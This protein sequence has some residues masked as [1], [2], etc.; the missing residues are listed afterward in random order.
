MFATTAVTHQHSCA[1]LHFTSSG[2]K[3]FAILTA[4]EVLPCRLR[5]ASVLLAVGPRNVD[6]K[7]YPNP[8]FFGTKRSASGP[9]GYIIT[10]WF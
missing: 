8:A 9:L 6:V 7:A 1:S 3:E 2:L 5:Q 10:D 4:V